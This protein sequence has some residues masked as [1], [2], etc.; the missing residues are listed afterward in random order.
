MVFF[1][2]FRNGCININFSCRGSSDHIPCGCTDYILKGHFKNEECNC[3]YCSRNLVLMSCANT[4]FN[5]KDP[6]FLEINAVLG[7]KIEKFL[8]M[9]QEKRQSYV[10]KAINYLEKHDSIHPIHETLQ[11]QMFLQNYWMLTTAHRST[12]EVEN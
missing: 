10:E 12:N 5:S 1:F 9:P 11:V 4:R 6:D 2:P 3:G 8:D 7:D